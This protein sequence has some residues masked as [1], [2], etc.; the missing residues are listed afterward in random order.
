MFKM[1]KLANAKK[2]VLKWNPKMEDKLI[3]FET[4][5]K[6]HDSLLFGSEMQGE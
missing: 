4:I 3:S 6:Y 5:R 1:L 2:R